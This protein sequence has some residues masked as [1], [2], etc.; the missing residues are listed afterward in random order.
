MKDT[1]KSLCQILLKKE[2]SIPKDTLFLDDETFER[3]CA[4]LRGKNKAGIFKD[5]TLL[6]IPYVE[7]LAMLGAKHLD[8]LI[9]GVNEGWDSCI[10]VT[11][12]RPQPDYAVGFG[13]SAFSD[14]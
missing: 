14:D 3:F 12:P 5:L 7:P 2:Q 8:M 4:K 13:R 10:A 9:E 11:R 6:I 1:C